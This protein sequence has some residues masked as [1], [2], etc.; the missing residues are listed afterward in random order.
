MR[1]CD[2]TFWVYF[3]PLSLCFT[4]KSLWTPYFIQNMYLCFPW[5]LPR[6]QNSVVSN[7]S[8]PFN[9]FFSYSEGFGVESNEEQLSFDIIHATIGTRYN[10]YAAVATRTFLFNTKAHLAAKRWR[11]HNWRS[12]GNQWLDGIDLVVS[13]CQKNCPGWPCSRSP[14]GCGAICQI[15]PLMPVAHWL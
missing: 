2:C 13:T 5:S 12:V 14:V 1:K 3:F 11:L 7:M 4:L 10:G 9:L 15:V 8:L 6:L